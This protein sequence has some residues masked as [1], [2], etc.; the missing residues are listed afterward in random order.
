MKSRKKGTEFPQ[1][2]TRTPALQTSPLHPIM[3]TS[4]AT[5]PLLLYVQPVSTPKRNPR[6]RFVI[7]GAVPPDRIA[8]IP[9]GC[10]MVLA[11]GDAAISFLGNPYVARNADVQVVISGLQVNVGRIAGE[12]VSGKALEGEHFKDT[13]VRLVVEECD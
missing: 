3:N 11:E 1:G 10:F 5:L 8:S 6:K 4:V 13:G 7:F 2:H 9:P 12:V